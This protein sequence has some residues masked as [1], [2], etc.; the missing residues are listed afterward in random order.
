VISF[1]RVVGILLGDVTRGGQQFIEHSRIP[2]S[3]V[4]GHFG[5]A[6]A[7]VERMG[8]EPAGDREIP[9]LCDEDV[10]D[11]AKLVDRPV[12][13]DPPPGDFDVRFVDE[14]PITGGVPAGLCC[15]DQ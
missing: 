12:Q 5:R 11:L 3:P 6:W 14:P 13:I 4:G 15:V 7:V 10:N 2:R 9:F 1:D 8:E